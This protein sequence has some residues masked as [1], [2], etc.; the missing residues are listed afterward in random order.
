MWMAVEQDALIL[1]YID[2]LLR[3][4]HAATRRPDLILLFEKLQSSNPP[5]PRFPFLRQETTPHETRTQKRLARRFDTRRD[6]PDPRAARVGGRK[7]G[8]RHG[9]RK[10]E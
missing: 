6:P 1:N 4:L 8:P 7:T 2:V 5:T 9:F 10:A 3:W